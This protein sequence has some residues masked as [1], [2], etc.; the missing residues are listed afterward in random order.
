[1]AAIFFDD[2]ASSILTRQAG[3]FGGGNLATSD[4]H[5]AMC[6]LDGLLDQNQSSIRL[7]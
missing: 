5:L 2:R 6:G 1:M 4:A 3:S 7:S